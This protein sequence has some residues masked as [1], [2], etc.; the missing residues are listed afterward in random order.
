VTGNVI[1]SGIFLLPAVLA[2]FGG[3]SVI[4]WLLSAGG[5]MTVALVFAGL[6]MQVLGSGGPYVWAMTGMTAMTAMIA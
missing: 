4:G 3:I 2:S 6:A 1:G 5:A